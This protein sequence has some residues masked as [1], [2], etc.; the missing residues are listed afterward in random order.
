MNAAN[1]GHQHRA[2]RPIAP[3]D[4]QTEMSEEETSEMVGP[5]RASSSDGQPFSA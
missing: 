4:P 2:T 5:A 3:A 1:E